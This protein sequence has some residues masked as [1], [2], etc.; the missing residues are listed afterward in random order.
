M[1]DPASAPPSSVAC[2]GPKGLLPSPGKAWFRTRDGRRF[3]WEIGVIIVVKLALLIVLWFVFIKPWP[4]PDTAP[5]ITV[6]QLYLPSGP[7][8]RHD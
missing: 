3:G 7:S 2:D 6:Q 8:L 5:P 1:T 4:R